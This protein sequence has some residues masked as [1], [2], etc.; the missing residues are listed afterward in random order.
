MAN[1]MHVFRGNHL[2]AATLITTGSA[3]NAR[4][5]P[6]WIGRMVTG[7]PTIKVEVQTS[8]GWMPRRIAS[9]SPVPPS[10]SP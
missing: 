2:I 1:L 5:V 9:S 4:R 8:R 6:S 3:I 10:P 7:D